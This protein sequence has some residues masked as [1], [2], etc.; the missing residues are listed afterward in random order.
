MLYKLDEPSDYFYLIIQG[1]VTVHSGQEGFIIE[2]SSF[3]Y[4]GVEALLNDRYSPDFTAEVTKYAR[5]LKIKRLD[6]RNAISS[7]SNFNR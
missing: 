6:Y 3:N 4:L 1:K 2:L 7:N 5:L